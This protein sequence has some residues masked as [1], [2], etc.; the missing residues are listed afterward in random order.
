[1]CVLLV[2]VCVLLVCVC[3]C[4][5]VCRVEGCGLLVHELCLT[6]WLVK[7]CQQVT[8]P[9]LEELCQQVTEPLLEEL[10]Q[11]DTEPL[12][13]ELCQLLVTSIS[14]TLISLN[15]GKQLQLALSIVC[16]LSTQERA[17][18]LSTMF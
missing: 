4:V 17:C 1:M 12:L 10:C 2:C 13:E 5:C 15:R 11:Q 18:S 6:Q 9:L 3:V 14:H 8:E 16:T 7:Q